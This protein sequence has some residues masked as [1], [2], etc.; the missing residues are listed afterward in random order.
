M[1]PL[2]A[3]VQAN[4]ACLSVGL[5]VALLLLCAVITSSKLDADITSWV[6]R[7]DRLQSELQ[8]VAQ[9]VGEGSGSTSQLLVQAAKNDRH[10]QAT[11]NILTVDSLMVHLEALAIATHVTVEHFDVTWSIKDLCFTPQLPEFDGLH[12]SMI[13][14]NMMPCAI[15]T[16]LDCFW[17]GSKLLGP[18]HPVSFSSL[19]PKFKWTSL[20]P[21]LMVEAMQRSHPNTLFPYNTLIDWM[22]RVG[23]VSGYQMK[24]CLD[25]TDPNC[26]YTAPNKLSG[27]AP[28][29]GAHLTG[30][31]RGLMANHWH[32]R[33]EEI[34]SG[35][36]RNHSTGQIVRADALQSTIQLMGEQDMYDYWR[37]TSKVQDI[38]NWSADKAKLILDSW[39]KSFK[40]QLAQFTRTSNLS[41]PF[42]I[43]AMT[44]KSML[45]PI[46]IYSLLDITT[47]EICFALMTIFTCFTFPKFTLSS[48]QPKQT[49]PQNHSTEDQISQFK[50]ISLAIVTSSFVALTF[51]ASLGLS[52]F[53]N[54][55]LNMATT[56]VLPPLALCHGFNQLITMANIYSRKFKSTRLD[57]LTIECLV[58]IFPFVKN[59]AIIYISTLLFATIIPITATRVFALQAISY[60]LLASLATVILLPSILT[61]FLVHYAPRSNCGRT[62]SMNHSLIRPRKSNSHNDDLN[63]EEQILSRIQDDLKNIQ[64]DSNQPT[65]FNFSARLESDGVRTSFKL[66]TSKHNGSFGR[67]TMPF[68]SDTE[69]CAKKDLNHLPDLLQTT[70]LTESSAL[71]SKVQDE[72]ESLKEKQEKVS[73]ETSTPRISAKILKAVESWIALAIIALLAWCSLIFIVSQVSSIDYG[74]R[75]RD[76]VAHGTPDYE[77]FRIQEKHFPVYN[78]F[79][80]TKG[81]F[82]YPTN[83]RLLHDFYR[84]IEN[85]EGVVKEHETSRFWLFR[86]R[87]WL[88]ELQEKFDHDRNKSAIY[89]EGWNQ[90]ASDAAKLAY[91]LLAQTG[92]V[93]NPI[94]KSIV[95]ANRLVD[96]NGIINPKAF[97]YYLTAWVFNDPTSYATSEANFKPEPKNWNDNPE[98]LKIEK[99]KNLNYAQIPFLVKLPENR[100]SIMTISEIRSKSQAFEHLNLPNFPTGIPFIFGDQFLKLDLLV[101]VA[102]SIGFALMFVLIGLTSREFGTAAIITL[103]TMLTI[104]EVYG[105]LGSVMMPVNNIYAVLLI[106]SIGATTVHYTISPKIEK[107]ASSTRTWAIFWKESKPLLMTF[108]IFFICI[109]ASQWSRIDFISKYSMLLMTMALMNS[110]NSLCLK[111]LVVRIF[112]SNQLIS[113][114]TEATGQQ[115][116]ID[117]LDLLRS[118][119]K[120]ER[121]I[122]KPRKKYRGFPRMKSNISLSTISEETAEAHVHDLKI[123]FSI[124]Y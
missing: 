29:I 102:S 59:Q 18:E 62:K 87:N 50:T 35:V 12:V 58:E 11:S 112:G 43:H 77:S 116:P 14:E 71:E 95:E 113:Q 24:P 119:V 114:K 28:D 98:D 20:N 3:F 76:I 30:G 4:S 21:M 72:D 1:R 74:L 6:Q 70:S 64:V 111:P 88:L 63:F 33:E 65:N 37:K 36:V 49:N 86:F 103:P 117:S 107:V 5:T 7:T 92:R 122:S 82:D 40:D 101:M 80:V 51:I 44:S 54:L 89:T 73:V 123:D 94:D 31:C 17:E 55:P 105:L 10:H 84:T 83:Q 75:L 57:R 121:R 13:L 79:A 100:D 85:V 22:R 78:I 47:F 38:N 41:K 91:K 60:I 26:P 46:D 66:I 8:Y 69:S 25:P 27:H 32:W 115:K 34:V 48:S 61:T 93:D 53:L 90:D 99:A 23:I 104:I 45:E 9:A 120:G 118:K 42:K 15:K 16:P 67:Q 109:I 19:G 56:Q 97:Y 2:G 108:T 39:Q 124:R 52:S 110:V 81:N 96:A 106:G 68:D